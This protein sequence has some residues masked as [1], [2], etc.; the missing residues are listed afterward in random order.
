MPLYPITRK[1]QNKKFVYSYSNG[2]NVTNKNVIKRINTLKIPP[3]YQDVFIFSKNSNVQYTAYD[4]KRR[5]Q[6]GYHSN[7][8]KKRSIKKFK[9]LIVFINIYPSL[10]N[11]INDILQNRIVVDKTYIFA[12]II[13]LIDICKIRPG[14]DKYLNSTGSYGAITLC[15]KHFTKKKKTIHLKFKGKSKIINECDID[16]E[17]ILGRKLLK[18]INK[19]NNNVCIFNN[20]KIKIRPRD[21]NTFLF[22]LTGKKIL[23]K[24]FRHYHANLLFLNNIF[25]LKNHKTKKDRKK[26]AKDVVEKSANK[27]HHTST[28]FKKSY[29][30]LPIH[31]LYIND[32]STFKKVFKKETLQSNIVKY[33]KKTT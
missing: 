12:I 8:I 9:E 18:L 7:F 2:S 13:K 6:K 30:F 24:Y 15:K 10:M 17:N 14:D 5:I 4:T 33:I 31:D 16:I 19:N 27:L 29:L 23:V 32:Y 11:K 1:I 22:K 20:F 25:K 3:A 28:I 26:N 21:I